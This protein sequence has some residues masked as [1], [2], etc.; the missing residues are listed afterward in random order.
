MKILRSNV[1]IVFIFTILSPFASAC[2]NCITANLTAAEFDSLSWDN[3]Q[4]V[5]V[6]TVVK[7][8]LSFPDNSMPVIT[9]TLMTEE[10]FKGNPDTTG[11]ILSRRTIRPWHSDIEEWVCGSA[12]VF[13]G[14]RLLIFSNPDQ[15]V[16]IGMCSSSRVV[17]RLNSPIS[18]DTRSTLERMRIWSRA[19]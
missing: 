7:A 4:N 12:E 11:L 3:S 2:S 18:S 1:F 6:G 13:I 5:Y 19:L 8:E 16:Y 9:Y 15:P 14:D 10:V 17:E